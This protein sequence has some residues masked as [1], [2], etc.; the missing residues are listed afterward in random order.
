MVCLVD[1]VQSI[2]QSKTLLLPEHK[3]IERKRVSLETKAIN[4][5]FAGER[6]EGFVWVWGVVGKGMGM[7]YPFIQT[8]SKPMSLQFISV[9]ELAAYPLAFRGNRQID[10]ALIDRQG[11]ETVLE[12]VGRA[13]F[14]SC[15]WDVLPAVE[16]EVMWRRVRRNKV[17]YDE[18]ER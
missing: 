7:T 5:P 4:Q 11:H 9:S 15:R 18:S 17:C 14:C 16:A 10:C 2:N 1:E 3:Q 8:W 6:A 12:I 13:S